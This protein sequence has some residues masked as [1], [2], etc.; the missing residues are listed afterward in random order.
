MTNNYF[1]A[2]T[3]TGGAACAGGFS[4]PVACIDSPAYL[5]LLEIGIY[6]CRTNVCIP[7]YLQSQFIEVIPPDVITYADAILKAHIELHRSPNSSS[8]EFGAGR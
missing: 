7:N 5:A 6:P 2:S 8:K 1:A 4:N 3:T